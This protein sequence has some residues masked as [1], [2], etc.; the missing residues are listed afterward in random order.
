MFRP[1]S[2][3]SANRWLWIR[4]SVVGI[5][6]L[7]GGAVLASRYSLPAS[8]RPLCP[9][10]PVSLSASPGGWGEINLSWSG[11]PGLGGL[12]NIYRSDD[13]VNFYFTNLQVYNGSGRT[14]TG[15][16]YNHTYSFYV[17][18]E[19]CNGKSSCQ[20]LWKLF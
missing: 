16:S 13:G 15:L 11:T 10:G 1:T 18:I 20:M 6:V 8:A 7:L 4:L 3:A 17:T 2:L 5:L 14:I 19:D 12:Y 9:T